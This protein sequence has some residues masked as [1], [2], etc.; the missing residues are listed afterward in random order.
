VNTGF[1]WIF[2]ALGEIL[3]SYKVVKMTQEGQFINYFFY[4]S[5]THTGKMQKSAYLWK[6]LIYVGY[7]QVRLDYLCGCVC[8]FGLASYWQSEWWSGSIKCLSPRRSRIQCPVGPVPHVIQDKDRQDRISLV[9]PVSSYITLTLVLYRV[10]IIDRLKLL[11]VQVML[12]GVVHNCQNF[13]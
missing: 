12:L 10:N 7:L 4:E 9:A 13:N 6:T 11:L 8:Q 1:R 3:W 5:G 2:K